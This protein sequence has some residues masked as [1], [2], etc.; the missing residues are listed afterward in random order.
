MRAKSVRDGGTPHF[1]TCFRMCSRTSCCRS[2]SSA[3][4][5]SSSAGV[6]S[7]AADVAAAARLAAGLSRFDGGGR[8]RVYD[9]AT[10]PEGDGSVAL[11]RRHLVA[12]G[13][14]RPPVRGTAAPVLSSL[15]ASDARPPRPGHTFRAD[16]FRARN[17]DRAPSV[18]A[19]GGICRASFWNGPIARRASYCSG[20][21]SCRQRLLSR[22][23]L[24]R[25]V[26][27]DC[28]AFEH[29]APTRTLSLCF[30]AP[31]D[32]RKP[33][34]S[35]VGVFPMMIVIPRARQSSSA[36]GRWWVGGSR[37]RCRIRAPQSASTS[38][39]QRVGALLRASFEA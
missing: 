22:R 16:R 14:V 3:P 23:P 10:V 1:R 32:D 28:S 20:Q 29:R 2:V 19:D 34:S 4:R 27:S 33:S 38:S 17:V 37:A 24:L 31:G 26:L 9:M 13:V 5:I 8:W 25:R 12:E 21:V 7:A 36:Y 6:D 15:S 30:F 11:A 18:C 39:A 35:S